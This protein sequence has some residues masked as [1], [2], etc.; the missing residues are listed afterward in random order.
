ML[1]PKDVDWPNWYKNKTHTYTVYK[2]T[3]SDLGTQKLKKKGWKKILHVNGNQKKPG[4]AIF[5]SDK[6][7]FKIKTVTKD[8]EGHYLMFKGSIQEDIAI[9]NFYAQWC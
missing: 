5:M 2:R 7:D 3:T 4:V 1:Q 9:I 6:T 8:K